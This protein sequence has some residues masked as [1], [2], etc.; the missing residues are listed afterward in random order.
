MGT[1]ERKLSVPAQEYIDEFEE[2]DGRPTGHG[3]WND[4][5][6]RIAQ[7]AG[8][9]PEQV[10]DITHDIEELAIRD[11][12]LYV[13]SSGG[14]V[15]GSTQLQ[16]LI[17]AAVKHRVTEEGTTWDDWALA[18]EDDYEAASEEFHKQ[19]ALDQLLRELGVEHAYMIAPDQ[20]LP[21]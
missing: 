16:V 6:L 7:I 4:D 10:R 13:E 11:F 3:Y 17:E 9:T 19:R 8:E 15:L 14:K 5:L 1:E 2:Q 21:R 20:E 18:F 12:D